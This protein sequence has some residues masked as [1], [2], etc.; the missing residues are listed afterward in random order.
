MRQTCSLLALLLLLTVMLGGAVA[1]QDKAAGRFTQVT[2]Q[3]DVLK[4][5]KL[6]ATSAKVADAVHTGDLIR[7]KSQSKA[8]VQ[9]IDDT[10]LD[11]SP[12]S[13]VVI[14]KFVY[15][16]GTE[17]QATLRV[18]LG[19]VYTNVSKL[20]KKEPD[21]T[22][23]TDTAVIGVRGT[24]TFV[25]KIPQATDTYNEQGTVQGSNINPAIPGM[26]TAHDMEF[27]RT[28]ENQPPTIPVPFSMQD[29][30]NL[31][32]VLSVGLVPTATAPPGSTT[33]QP[34]YRPLGVQ[35]GMQEG[36]GLPGGI[37][38]PTIPPSIPQ[39]VGPFHGS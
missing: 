13:R 29:L 32:K 5:G 18:L 15:D 12:N 24:K 14:D 1:A 31:R 17:R 35:P 33:G 21:F 9:F 8:Q 6:P 38:I 3:V 22:I 7:T 36:M 10:L 16:G 39:R 19:M 28:G 34:S 20:F 23:E 26:V 25:L 2:G 4:A 11:I 27:F 30:Q 37:T